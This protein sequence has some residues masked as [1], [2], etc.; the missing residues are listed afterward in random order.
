MLFLLIVLFCGLF[1]GVGI[2]QWHKQANRKEICT[3]QIFGRVVEIVRHEETDHEGRSVTYTPVFAYTV[4]G[5]EYRKT[6]TASSSFCRFK[7][8]DEVTVY[9]DPI[10]PQDSYVLEDRAGNLVGPLFAAFGALGIILAV[11]FKISGTI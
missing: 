2:Y 9:Y 3:A 5:Y 1:L 4:A 10:D 11:V 8:G 6:S 7:Q